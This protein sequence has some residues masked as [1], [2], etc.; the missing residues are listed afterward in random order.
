MMDKQTLQAYQSRW[1]AVADFERSERKQETLAQRWRKLDSLLAMAAALGLRPVRDEEGE[2]L[3]RQRWN[4]L[5]ARYL[6]E[7]Q[8]QG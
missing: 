7:S 2:E 3:I 1:Q 5:A 6:A 4:T 8:E